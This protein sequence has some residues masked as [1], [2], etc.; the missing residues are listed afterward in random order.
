MKN[1]GYAPLACAAL[2]L[3]V[4][5]L[6]VPTVAQISEFGI[7]G[8]YKVQL[9]VLPPGSFTGPKADLVR[10]GG[11]EPVG[12]GGSEPPNHRLAVFVTENGRLVEQAK[13]VIVYRY[14]G[15]VSSRVGW[16]RLPVV[17]AHVAGRGLETTQFGNNVRLGPGLS[18]VR[19]SVNDEGGEIFRFVLH[20]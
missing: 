8:E 1:P 12:P 14:I 15:K 7:A 18:E 4:F 9:E 16:V 2:S 11:G 5:T 3:L 17:Q 13:V 19:V 10:D 6:P 20:S